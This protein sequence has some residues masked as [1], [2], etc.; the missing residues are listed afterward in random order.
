MDHAR[1]RVREM[2]LYF[3]AYIFEET[4]FSLFFISFRASFSPRVVTVSGGI[5]ELRRIAMAFV[6]IAGIVKFREVFARSARSRRPR[7]DPT[8]RD[9]R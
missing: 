2:Q 5:Y 6:E 1:H 7:N 4:F 9:K 8:D 3:R